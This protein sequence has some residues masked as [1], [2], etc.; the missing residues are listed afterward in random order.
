[1]SLQHTFCN[2]NRLL[3]K[4]EYKWLLNGD[5]MFSCLHIFCIII[6]Y[7]SKVWHMSFEIISPKAPWKA[8]VCVIYGVLIGMHAGCQLL[9]INWI[10]SKISLSDQGR[11]RV[12]LKDLRLH[13]PMNIW[14][15]SEGTGSDPPSDH[16]GVAGNLP[17]LHL[18]TFQQFPMWRHT[19]ISP[20]CWRVMQRQSKLKKCPFHLQSMTAC[21][22]LFFVSVSAS[23]TKHNNWFIPPSKT[24]ALFHIHFVCQT[25]TGQLLEWDPA[26]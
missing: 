19:T 7:I 20:S 2:V 16:Q 18:A 22:L 12:R 11:D 17:Y 26:H 15:L 9:C 23:K 14:C 3:A 25:Y 13:L 21:L 5:Q 4:I 6:I 8:P 24:K 1:M 10:R